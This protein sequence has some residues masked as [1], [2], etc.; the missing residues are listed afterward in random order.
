[1]RPAAPGAGELPAVES[2]RSREG[3]G[4]E[5]FAALPTLTRANSLGQFL[6]VNGRPVRDKLLGGAVRGKQVVGEQV[7]MTAATLFQ[8]RVSE[9]VAKHG[10][11]LLKPVM[12][13]D[14]AN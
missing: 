2:F 8:N 12:L 3:L 1:M 11:R 10:A 6:F 7:Q 5:G 9:A 14:P 4:V 13:A